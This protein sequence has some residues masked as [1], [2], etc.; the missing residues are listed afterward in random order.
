[1]TQGAIVVV[2]A[3]LKDNISVP[4]FFSFYNLLAGAAFC[5][6]LSRENAF[7]VYSK[8]HV[9]HFLLSL[10]NHKDKCERKSKRYCSYT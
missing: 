8:Q 4:G 9:L 2:N 3:Q 6:Q 7:T 1:M 5:C 10:I